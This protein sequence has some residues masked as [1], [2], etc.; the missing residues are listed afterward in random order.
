MGLTTVNQYSGFMYTLFSSF[1]H[2]EKVKLNISCYIHMFIIQ[3][4]DF[5]G[6]KV[7]LYFSK[8]V[9][10]TWELWAALCLKLT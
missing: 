6:G 3:Y 10:L 4:R 2:W 1:A 9:S 5:S 7:Y 8:T